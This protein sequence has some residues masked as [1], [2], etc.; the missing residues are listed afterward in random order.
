MPFRVEEGSRAALEGAPREH[1]GARGKHEGSTREQQGS[2]RELSG[3]SVTIL[4]LD[5][6]VGNVAESYVI[7]C[8]RCAI[9]HTGLLNPA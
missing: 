5:D 6:Y 3:D 1:E 8:T 9:G 4:S 2:T 7:E